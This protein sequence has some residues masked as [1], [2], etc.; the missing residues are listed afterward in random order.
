M[1][2]DG[3]EGRR[4]RAREW[5]RWHNRARERHETARGVG[6]RADSVSWDETA[7]AGHQANRLGRRVSVKW[8]GGV[9]T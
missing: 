6:G 5:A 3:A 9:L 8:S 4:E 7:G 1:H 2:K